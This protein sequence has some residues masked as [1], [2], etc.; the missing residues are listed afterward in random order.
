MTIQLK[1]TYRGLSPGM[2]CDE[3]RGLLQ[4]HGV[5][6]VETESQTYALPSG[7]TQSRTTLALKTQTEQEKEFGGVH[8]LGS[9]QDETKMLLDIDETVFPQERL[10]A[11]QRDLDFILGSYEIKW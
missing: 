11:F 7:D 2:L 4:K 1:K 6:V 9:P 3:V 5:V 8:I 10:S